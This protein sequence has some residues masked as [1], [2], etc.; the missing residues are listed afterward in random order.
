MKRQHYSIFGIILIITLMASGCTTLTGRITI[1]GNE[2]H[3]Q[4]VLVVND[5]EEYI[6]IGELAET[7]RQEYQ[8]RIVRVKGEIVKKKVS[9]ET[10]RACCA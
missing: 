10:R 1:K 3:T 2:P 9:R 5:T 7:L 8:N 4:V 6:I